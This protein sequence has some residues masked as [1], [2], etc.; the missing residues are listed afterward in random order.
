MASRQGRGEP[1]TALAGGKWVISSS[2]ADV[3]AFYSEIV[4]IADGTE[5]WITAIE[6]ILRAGPE[7]RQARN[8]RA[9]PL[10]AA[11]TWEAIATRMA[12]L[13]DD[14]LGL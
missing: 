14:Q 7:E 10:L 1:L 2:V 8:Q 12:E 4:T 6:A 9:Q 13:V 3:V 11:N 5:A